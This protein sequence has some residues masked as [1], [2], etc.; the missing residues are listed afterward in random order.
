MRPTRVLLREKG[1][2]RPWSCSSRCVGV[3]SSVV[4]A[5]RHDKRLVICGPEAQF[6]ISPPLSGE[7]SVQQEKCRA[8]Y[9]ATPLD[10]LFF[11][12][13]DFTP[14]SPQ[15]RECFFSTAGARCIWQREKRVISGCLPAFRQARTDRRDVHIIRGGR[16]GWVQDVYESAVGRTETARNGMARVC[17]RRWTWR[18]CCRACRASASLCWRRSKTP[19][20]R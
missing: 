16:W 14:F 8:H 3:C 18:F 4:G 20:P 1:C 17:V 5:R 10:P 12:F 11:V 2:A 6:R 7:D 15:V 13:D 19:I 9:G